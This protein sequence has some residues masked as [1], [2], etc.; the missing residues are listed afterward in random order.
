MLQTSATWRFPSALT[1]VPQMRR[2]LRGL[3]SD[4]ALSYDQT[5]DLLL[6][7]SEAANNAVEH[8]QQ[9]TEPFFD[10]ST[11]VDDGRVTIVIQDYGGWQQPTALFHRGRGLAMMRA[12]ADTTV[13]PRSHG[14]TVTIQSR[15]TG[16]VTLGA[17]SDV[18]TPSADC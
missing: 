2:G 5:E 18:E 4:S 16:P 7:A 10:V 9:P 8:A 3:L 1:S 15:C 6:A 12:L 14:T 13:T 11:E 17:Q